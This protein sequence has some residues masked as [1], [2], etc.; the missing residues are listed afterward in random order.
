MGGKTWENHKSLYPNSWMMLDGLDGLFHGKS[1]QKMD[2]DWGYQHF[3]KPLVRTE[4]TL[5]ET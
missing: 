3:R 2:D 1:T 4:F 5:R